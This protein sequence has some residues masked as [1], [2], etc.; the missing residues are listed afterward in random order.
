MAGSPCPAPASPARLLFK[1]FSAPP[2]NGVRPR[3][4]FGGVVRVG[5]SDSSK[6]DW[7]GVPGNCLLREHIFSRPWNVGSDP[8]IFRGRTPVWFLGS[9]T[10]S[11]ING[12]SLLRAL[13]DG[14]PRDD[15]EG[16]D[17]HVADIA[18]CS[19]PWPILSKRVAPFF[20]GTVARD[21]SRRDGVHPVTARTALR[22]PRRGRAEVLD[23]TRASRPASATCNRVA[24]IAP[25][26]PK[27]GDRHCA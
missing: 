10:W 18:T 22:S 8:G 9:F 12:G 1:H 16:A 17:G 11:A 27:C 24:F 3:G 19:R 6:R 13:D 23:R 5:V 14:A 4:Y 15:H 26:S 7:R 2:E 21:S 20:V 25:G